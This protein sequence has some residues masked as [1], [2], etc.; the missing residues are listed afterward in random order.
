MKVL[1]CLIVG[2]LAPCAV[3]AQE[4]KPPVILEKVNDLKA[5]P[6]QV[7]K[8]IP[9]AGTSRFWGVSKLQFEGKQV[10]IHIYDV[11]K[12]I[13]PENGKTGL[14]VLQQCELDIFTSPDKNN[15]KRI[16]STS[17]NYLRGGNNREGADSENVRVTTLWLNPK[18]K[19]APIL[20]VEL[21][22][23]GA[24]DTITKELLFVF[25]YGWNKP[26]IQKGFGSGMTMDSNA[27]GWN[28]TFAI[29]EVGLIIVY[30]EH[31]DNGS[32]RAFYR[33][34]E[35]DKAFKC[36]AC[37]QF[38]YD[39]PEMDIPLNSPFLSQKP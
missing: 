30:E 29:D 21:E 38:T 3:M 39:G 2:S 17:F 34:Q 15:F 19:T 16:S 36:F 13:C 33:W 32:W 31:S 7:Q 26:I 10:W 6:A 23:N 24:L 22:S 37:K 28:T 14:R 9:K 1:L 35:S 18:I 25:P 20:T 12:A 4:V 5:I 27:H 11:E 8:T